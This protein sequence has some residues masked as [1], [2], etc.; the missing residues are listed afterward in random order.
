MHRDRYGEHFHR[1]VF[2]MRI[3]S[4]VN[5]SLFLRAASNASYR[6][7]RDARLRRIAVWS[8]VRK[9]GMYFF[10]DWVADLLFFGVAVVHTWRRHAR[11]A[12]FLHRQDWLDRD[13]FV[14]AV[15]LE[16]LLLLLLLFGFD[17]MKRLVAFQPVTFP[18]QLV[19]R[20]L[21]KPLPLANMNFICVTRCRSQRVLERTNF[22]PKQNRGFHASSVVKFLDRV[23]PV[24]AVPLHFRSRM[25]RRRPSFQDITQRTFHILG[26][27]ANQISER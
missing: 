21:H 9:G 18:A 13:D 11:D 16:A 8:R 12:I 3:E 15:A 27:F 26:N 10:R 19:A 7:A 20:L 23:R 17:E 24:R 4:H 14:D 1:S 22:L 25:V 2:Y 6:N 5:R